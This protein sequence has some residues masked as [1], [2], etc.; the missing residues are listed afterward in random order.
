MRTTHSKARK[1][2]EGSEAKQEN[3]QRKRQ[4]QQA[5]QARQRKPR[6]NM[7][8]PN[9]SKTRGARKQVK[10]AESKPR[11]RRKTSGRSHGRKQGRH[12]KKSRKQSKGAKSKPRKAKQLFGD[13]AGRIC[14]CS[15]C[16]SSLALCPITTMVA[17]HVRRMYGSGARA[18]P[19]NRMN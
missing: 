7:C 3:K 2:A 11:M 5:R 18:R 8:H 14:C 10:Q 4:Q 19:C 1:Q 15:L 9:E 17:P 13:H 12:N 6:F 16:K